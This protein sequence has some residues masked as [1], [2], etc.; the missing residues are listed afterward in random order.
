M[1]RHDAIAPISS[2]KTLSAA[3]GKAPCHQPLMVKP[4]APTTFMPW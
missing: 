2:H 4:A 1:I 3:D